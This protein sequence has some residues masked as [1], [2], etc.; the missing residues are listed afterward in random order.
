[1]ITFSHFVFSFQ[2]QEPSASSVLCCKSDPDN[3]SDVK[4]EPEYVQ[5]EGVVNIKLHAGYNSEARIYD[6][7]APEYI[8]NDGVDPT[9]LYADNDSN[10]RIYDADSPY[11]C[12]V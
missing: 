7:Y 6:K 3:E 9:K 2:R 10:V 4:S 5:S 12:T 8:K 11:F 1:M